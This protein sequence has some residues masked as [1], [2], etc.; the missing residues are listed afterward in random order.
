VSGK[1]LVAKS[2]NLNLGLIQTFRKISKFEGEEKTILIPTKP[3]LELIGSL[4]TGE[5]EF[6][7]EDDGSKLAIETDQNYTT[8]QLGNTNEFPVLPEISEDTAQKFTI[9]STILQ[10]VIS[11]TIFAHSNDTSRPIITGIYLNSLKG[12][13]Y[14]AATDGYRLSDC[15]IGDWTD[16]NE[17]K[18]ILPPSFITELNSIISGQNGEVEFFI[19][20]ESLKINFQDSVLYSHIIDGKYPDYKALIPKETPTVLVLDKDELLQ[21]LRTTA[22]FAR[23]SRGAVII[24]TDSK[25]NTLMIKSLTTTYGENVA[26]IKTQ[27]S[28]DVEVSLNSRY[29]TDGIN[30]LSSDHVILGLSDGMRPV[31]LRQELDDNSYTHI[32]MPIRGEK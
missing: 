26:T 14:A 21:V 7:I 9:N 32:I 6:I 23:E 24:K 20:D 31:V 11:K 18:T 17:I 16:E 8:M 25:T 27:V 28:S 10:S 12:K 3:L 1:Q 30:S 13:L 15:L 29:L 2:T 4:P 22:I 5:I 19:T